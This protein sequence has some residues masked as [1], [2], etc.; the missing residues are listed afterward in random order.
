MLPA[1]LPAAAAA[2][3][4]VAE[5]AAPSEPPQQ[6]GNA[7]ADAPAEAGKKGAAKRGRAKSAASPAAPA[8]QAHIDNILSKAKRV[9]GTA[10]TLA[11]KALSKV[12]DLPGAL[13]SAF[14]PCPVG[15]HLEHL[16]SVQKI[17][18]VSQED[19]SQAIVVLC[20]C[21]AYLLNCLSSVS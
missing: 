16:S 4:P 17:W 18:D 15:L 20:E 13:C 19:L 3:P 8:R 2:A 21:F 7:A 14:F 10:K 1:E 12:V 11:V 9:A 5:T 6:E